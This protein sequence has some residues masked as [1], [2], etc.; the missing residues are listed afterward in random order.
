VDG[1]QLGRDL[2]QVGSGGLAPLD[3]PVHPLPVR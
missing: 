2:D 1:E 3:V